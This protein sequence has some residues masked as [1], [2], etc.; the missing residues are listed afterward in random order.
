MDQSDS[1]LVGFRYAAAGNVGCTWSEAQLDEWSSYSAG[2]P[3]NTPGYSPLLWYCEPWFRQRGT[4]LPM[5]ISQ[6]TLH[7]KIAKRGSRTS[8]LAEQARHRPHCQ[9]SKQGSQ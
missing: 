8:P 3:D 6:Y 7:S 2:L 1:T 4:G 5:W 9:R